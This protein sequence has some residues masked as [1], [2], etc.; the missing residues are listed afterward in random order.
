MKMG[1]VEERL[2]EELKRLQNIFNAGHS[3]TVKHL[4]NKIRYN[5]LGKTLCGECQGNIILIYEPEEEASMNVLYHEYIE[6]IFIVP[7]VKKYYEVLHNQQKMLAYKDK[8]LAEK[9]EVI[10]Q[11]LMQ[12]KEDTV[13]ALSNQIRKLA[14]ERTSSE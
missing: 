3:L 5:K 2:K 12:F 10:H 4:P 8:M 11:L 13:E 9:D 6:A 14:S 1:S 7:L